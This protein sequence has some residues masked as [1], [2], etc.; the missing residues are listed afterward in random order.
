MFDSKYMC[1]HDTL[2][3]EYFVK[4]AIAIRLFGFC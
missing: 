1:K 4:L 3:L 2:F